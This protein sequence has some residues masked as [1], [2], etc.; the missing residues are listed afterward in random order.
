MDCA[1]TA[2]AQGCETL[3]GVT[4]QKRNA[5]LRMSGVLSSC[6]FMLFARPAEE[7]GGR[8]GQHGRRTW[9]SKSSLE[10]PPLPIARVYLYP[11][12]GGFLVNRMGE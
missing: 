5:L 7:R 10:L 3:D 11:G 12:G 4:P 2:E 8:I 9:E 1:S 6:R